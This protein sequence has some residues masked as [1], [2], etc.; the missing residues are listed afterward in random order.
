MLNNIR[1][2][3]GPS[4]LVAAAFIGP[5]TL[6]VC[7]ITGAAHGFDLL[8][9][10]LFS[11]LATISFQEMSLRLGIV[12]QNGLG[13]AIRNYLPSG[14]LKILFS[15][16]VFS[17]IVIGNAAYEAG[18][19]SGAVL[20]LEVFHQFKLWPIIIGSLAF[21]LLYR[22]K[23]KII[24][25]TLIA[26]V[27]LMCVCFLITAIATQPS[28]IEILASFWPSNI[29]NLDFLTI[30]AIIGTTVVPYNLFL[31]ASMISE[32]YHDP[33]KLGQARW[34]NVIAI[35]LGGIISILI[36]IVSASAFHAKGITISNASDMAIQ[37]EPILGQNAKT[38]FG[39]GL[40]AAGLSSAITAPLAASYAA[41]G[42]FGWSKETNAYKFRSVWMIILGIGV[43]FS[44]FGLKFISIIKF[45]QIANGLLLPIIALYLIYLCNQESI[46]GRFKNKLIPN[47]FA[48]VVILMTLLL[49]YKTFIKLFL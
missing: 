15:L 1:K 47:I 39:I 48:G 12:T 18:N 10:M 38:L 27:V 21:A 28:V 23:Y 42:L 3:F 49:S 45:A 17:A 37:L 22:G 8:W 26:L 6:T 34:E 2:Y 33:S 19:I 35:S 25:T 30:M 44:F 31:H 41:V 36:M 5:G 13:E 7:S 16:I 4:T 14:A 29:Q 46:M 40:F 43:C 32:K 24:E 20:G 9:A 11:I